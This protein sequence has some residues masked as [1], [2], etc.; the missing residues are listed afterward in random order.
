MGSTHYTSE[1]ETVNKVLNN[2]FAWVPNTRRLITNLLPFHNFREREPQQFGMISFTD[3]PPEAAHGP[4]S[5][6]GNYGIVISQEWASSNNIQKVFYIDSEGS[7]FEALRSLFKYAYDDLVKK[8][9]NREGEVS[10][11]AFTNKARAA[12]AGGILYA[13]LLELYEYMEPIEHSYQQEWRIVYPMPWGKMVLVDTIRLT[14]GR[15]LPLKTLTAEIVMYHSVHP[16]H[17]TVF[18]LDAHL[19]ALLIVSSISSKGGDFV[20]AT[21]TEYSGP[22]FLFAS[23]SKSFLSS[24]VNFGALPKG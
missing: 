8:S 23:Y 24:A 2:G 16:W 22:R 5:A 6:F 4:R 20:Y 1:I 19:F 17:Y 7:I 12:V 13:K 11:M 10:Q 9:L 14:L 15:R 21:E 3:L 18:K